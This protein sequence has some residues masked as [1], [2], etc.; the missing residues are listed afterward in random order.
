MEKKDRNL[1]TTLFKYRYLTT[2]LLL[3]IVLG[4][5]FLQYYLTCR[6]LI[7]NQTESECTLGT[8]PWFSID[9]IGNINQIKCGFV[10]DIASLNKSKKGHCVMHYN[11]SDIDLYKDCNMI[12]IDE[13]GAW[14]LVYPKND[15]GSQ[16]LKDSCL[17]KFISIQ[18]HQLMVQL[19]LLNDKAAQSHTFKLSNI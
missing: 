6:D 13:N 15:F 11:F 1:I 17:L 18:K 5:V 4:A 3:V 12:K 8:T 10:F 9:T 2:F 7:K 19:K 14:L 16:I